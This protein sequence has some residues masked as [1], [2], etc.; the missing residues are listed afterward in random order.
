[1]VVIAQGGRGGKGNRHFASATLRAPR[2]HQPG[3]EGEEL[4]VR[5]EL[6]MM[7]DV[8]LVGFPNA[9]KSTLISRISAARPK[10]ADY[11]FT[12]LKPNLGVVGVSDFESFVVADI[13]GIIEGAHEGAGLG[14]RF[15]RHI[16][17][18]SLLLLLVDPADPNRGP[19]DC[20]NILLDELNAFSERMR[21][22]K[23]M[24]ALTKADVTHEREEE[25]Q[26]LKTL[27]EKEGIPYHTISSV[28]GD[29]LNP[30]VRD[31]Y[32]RVKAERQT[33]ADYTFDET[34]ETTEATS[35]E[36]IDP[37]DEI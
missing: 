21:H 5:M 30:M 31:L 6:K 26:Q 34:E 11:P 7:A 32:E 29:G 23:R 22:K 28:R 15:L 13:P 36:A 37:L 12:T 2:F 24:V 14:I 20:Y 35:E 27:L 4:W 25:V 10:V 33:M 1:M 18:T 8:G 3:G 17:R 9:G 19:L 16:E